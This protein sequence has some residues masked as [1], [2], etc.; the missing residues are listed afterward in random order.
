MTLTGAG[1]GSKA[2]SRRATLGIRVV[3]MGSIE[4]GSLVS[5]Y[6]WYDGYSVFLDGRRTYPWLLFRQAC[7]LANHWYR[8]RC[9]S[10]TNDEQ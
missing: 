4:R 7:A 8:E 1:Y 3:R 5:G 9:C 10:L 2:E 6:R